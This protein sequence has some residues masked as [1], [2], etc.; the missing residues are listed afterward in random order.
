MDKQYLS[1]PDNPFICH[2]SPI[3]TNFG[4]Q[5]C[6]HSDLCNQYLN[7]TFPTFK[8]DPKS[9]VLYKKY[10]KLHRLSSNHLPSS[11]ADINN[12]DPLKLPFPAS[13]LGADSI[14]PQNIKN[15]S[16]NTRTNYTPI[17][18][19]GL[20]L[21]SC[22]SVFLAIF[23]FRRYFNVGYNC[24]NTTIDGN[25]IARAGEAAKNKVIDRGVIFS[26]KKIIGGCWW[27]WFNLYGRG[28]K[29]KARRRSSDYPGYMKS[30]ASKASSYRCSI[31][32]SSPS[33][34]K[35]SSNYPLNSAYDGEKSESLQNL[36]SVDNTTSGSG[37]GLPLLVQRTVA[38]T[39]QLVEIIGKGRYGVVWLGKWRGEKVAVK[40]FVSREENS[41]FREVQIY[42]TSMLR[43]ENILG[44]IA[45]DNKD[46]GTWTQLWLVTDYCENGSL[47]D[48]LQ[49]MV[50][51]IKSML[52]IVHSI[53]SGLAHLHMEI[54]GIQGKP[55]IAHRDLKCK[56]ILVK[57]DGTTCCLADLGLA[58][59][60]DSTADKLDLPLTCSA[61]NEIVAASKL[62]INQGAYQMVGTKRYMAPEIIEGS[63]ACIQ[64][65]SDFETRSDNKY[66][67][68]EMRKSDMT[69]FSNH[70]EALKRADIYALGL[71]FWEILRRCDFEGYHEDFQLAYFDY[72]P[73]DP[74][75]EE[76]RR[77]ICSEGRRPT[78]PP[79]WSQNEVLQSIAKIMKECWYHNPA[80]RLTALRV[81]KSLA[82]LCEESYDSFS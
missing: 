44:F 7:P 79:Q 68:N 40:I 76:M 45:A 35:H 39:I 15:G 67:N 27:W 4:I 3:N 74:T 69:N 10:N 23:A 61:Q 12:G 41:W 77:T 28:N 17:F 21:V 47:F 31:E 80:A 32:I 53:A 26:D 24:S 13:P 71:V 30:H 58:V 70:F 6:S 1:P 54:V 11:L 37:S 56:N 36:L 78:I 46:N 82:T 8:S 18:I 42:Q 63:T 50:L 43:H 22:L 16:N 19:A 25:S 51:D 14:H 49:K 73:P 9:A 72:V 75:I 33:L 65:S 20:V 5:C 55:A 60:Y 64:K 2:S 62:K 29:G 52:K 48:Y 59:C 66:S 34:V 57:R 38:R 81:K